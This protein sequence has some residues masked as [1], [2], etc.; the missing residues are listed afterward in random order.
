MFSTRTAAYGVHYAGMQ[1]PRCGCETIRI[2][3]QVKRGI[4]SDLRRAECADCALVVFTST[5]IT[6]V[7]HYDYHARKLRQ[8]PLADYTTKV[9][10]RLQDE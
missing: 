5:V 10:P 4:T 6:H 3:R 8:M 9:L 2:P 1:C 7:E